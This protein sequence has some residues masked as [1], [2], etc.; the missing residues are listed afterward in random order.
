MSKNTITRDLK[1]IRK[2]ERRIERNQAILA[3]C[4]A[5]IPALRQRV[6]GMI[7]N[8]KRRIER[9]HERLNFQGGVDVCRLFVKHVAIPELEDEIAE[10]QRMVAALEERIRV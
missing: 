4:A 1:I 8:D 2:C 3:D 5:L 6:V 7:E 10:L 9:A